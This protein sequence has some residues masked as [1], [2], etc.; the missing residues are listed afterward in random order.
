[1]SPTSD[2]INQQ[3]A[4]VVQVQRVGFDPEVEV[5]YLAQFGLVRLGRTSLKTLME[6]L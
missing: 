1:M 6:C 3:E 2:G 4:I 5:D